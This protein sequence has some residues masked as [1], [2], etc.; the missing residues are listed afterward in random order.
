MKSFSR[1]LFLSSMLGN[2]CSTIKSFYILTS[3]AFCNPFVIELPV[4]KIFLGATDGTETAEISLVISLGTLW[5]E[6]I[7]NL[8]AMTVTSFRWS[9]S[10]QSDVG[11][12]GIQT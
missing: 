11:S 1:C 10:Q 7:L 6:G 5:H 2:S 8:D 12:G 9:G 4:E 3:T